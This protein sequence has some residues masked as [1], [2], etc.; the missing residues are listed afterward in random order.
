[1]SPDS[2]AETIEAHGCSISLRRVD[3]PDAL[4][5]F[6]SCQPPTEATEAS[7]QAAA[8]Y[9]AIEDTLAAEGG[10]FES[11]VAETVFLRNLRADIEAVREA[12]QQ[13]LAAHEGS[14]NPAITEI[15]Q[16]P[17]N[18]GAGLEV[19]VQAVLPTVAPSRFEMFRA[20]PTCPC[21]ECARTSGLRVHVGEE[22]RFYA[23]AIY[24]AGDDAYQQTLALFEAAENLL[25]QAGMAFSDVMR[26]WIYIPEMERDY[27][28]LNRGRREFFAA[29]GID[30]IPAST[31][32]GAGLV[33]AEHA[34]GLGVYAVQAADPGAAPTERTVMTTP[35]L[36]EAPVYGSDFSRGMRI[37]EANKIALHI[38]G[39]ASLDESGATVHLDDFEAQ[40]ERMLVNVAALL[41]GQGASFGDV[42]SAITYLKHPD[43]AA[44]L[45]Q[46]FREA[47]YEG[48]PNV[49]VEA[50]V[51]RPELLCETEALAVLPRTAEPKSGTV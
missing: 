31:G 45:R 39:T 47:G 24:G 5:L 22:V 48:F 14:C 13:V 17:L 20:N 44:R 8:I 11:V 46:K 4:E 15:Q 21:A 33:P 43:D 7:A 35:T 6:L 28:G 19:L 18:H 40:A 1:M 29:R 27:P 2:F 3:G 42:V 36:N 51:C 41:E 38:S 16:P 32:I 12:R 34:I 25:Q 26:T 10:S 30:P 50:P 49:L 37:E 23:G 9:R